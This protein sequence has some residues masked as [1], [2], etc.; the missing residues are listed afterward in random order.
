M[1][2]VIEPCQVSLFPKLHDVQVLMNGSTAFQCVIDSSQIC[3]ISKLN[4]GGLYPF[5][6]VTDED[7]EQDQAQH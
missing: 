7:V 4:E 2:A 3:I 1:F 6:Q 5:V